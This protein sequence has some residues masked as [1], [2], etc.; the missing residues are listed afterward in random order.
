MTPWTAMTQRIENEKQVSDVAYCDSLMN[1]IEL[2]IRYSA[3]LLIALLPDDE[4]G[5][6]ERYRWE[7]ALLRASGIGTWAAAIQNL[8]GG[9]QYSALSN[10]LSAIGFHKA[11]EQFTARVADDDWQHKVV[12]AITEAKTVV[13]GVRQPIPPRTNLLEAFRRFVEV[14]NKLDVHGAPLSDIKSQVSAPLAAFIGLM[15]DNLELLRVPLVACRSTVS[16]SPSTVI[17]L[18]Q[19]LEP[20]VRTALSESHRDLSLPDGVYVVSGGL[21]RLT[22]VAASP[23]VG[24]FYVANGDARIAERTAEALSYSTGRSVRIPVD[25]WI[26]PPDRIAD[27]E[28]AA[29]ESL[30]PRVARAHECPDAAR[31]LRRTAC[32]TTRSVGHSQGSEAVRGHVAGTRGNR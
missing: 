10:R 13:T 22:L 30:V 4:A 23:D 8:A 3:A 14:R 18:S 28:T 25:D 29:L 26:L 9:T 15:N 21:Q 2:C 7:H 5:I 19:P 20:E 16:E 27:S 1:A 24:D 6:R 32:S 31:P 11:V 17:A 12:E